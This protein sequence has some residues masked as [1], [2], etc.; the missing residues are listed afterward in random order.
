MSHIFPLYRALIQEKTSYG[1][2]LSLNRQT[3]ACGSKM[4]KRAPPLIPG[5]QKVQIFYVRDRKPTCF[6]CTLAIKIL[7]QKQFNSFS[8][9]TV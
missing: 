9:K 8:S 5:L 6:N 4:V 2:Q 1:T 7:K 3:P